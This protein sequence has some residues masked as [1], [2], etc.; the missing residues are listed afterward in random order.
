MQ[1][2]TSPPPT[3]IPAHVTLRSLREARGLTAADLA[4]RLLE[5]GVSVATQHI[6]D[7]EVGRKNPGFD[8]RVAWADELG[9]GV[10]DFRTG[11]E[12]RELVEAADAEARA[13]RPAA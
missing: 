11:G 6:Y 7:V 5:R 9:V 3:L 12:L 13:G 10:R 1:R 4:A 8:L 2:I